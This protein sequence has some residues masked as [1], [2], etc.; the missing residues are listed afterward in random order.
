MTF[1]P[2]Y[3]RD[4]TTSLS[5]GSAGHLSTSERG[6]YVLGGLVMAAAGAKPRPNPLLNLIALG[7][8]AYLAWRGAEGSCPI[9]AMIKGDDIHRL[10]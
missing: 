6:M 4:S 8:G 10:R 1:T 5:S 7:A 2:S 3:S 9:K